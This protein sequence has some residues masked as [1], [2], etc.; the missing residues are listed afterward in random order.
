MKLFKKFLLAA[1]T[2]GLVGSLG[3]ATQVK[4]ADGIKITIDSIGTGNKINWSWENEDGD[5][6]YIK[7][8]S[9]EVG[10][11]EVYTF[12]GTEDDEEG[13][14][15]PIELGTE[16]ENH[17][18]ELSE[19]GESLDGDVVIYATATDGDEDS[20][21]SHSEGVAIKE[22]WYLVSANP[23]P[24]KGGTVTAKAGST[25]ITADGILVKSGTKV[26]AEEEEKSGYTFVQWLVNNT[27]AGT[28]PELVIKK[29][30]TETEIVAEYK[31]AEP[32]TTP[33]PTPTTTPTPTPTPIGTKA[34]LTYKVKLSDGT[35]TPERNVSTTPDT[36]TMKKGETITITTNSGARSWTKTQGDYFD[37]NGNDFYAKLAGTIQVKAGEGKGFTDSEYLTINITD[38]FKVSD[39]KIKGDDYVTGDKDKDYCIDLTPTDIVE[40]TGYKT[41][42]IKW[43]V[44]SDSKATL[45]GL[46]TTSKTGTSVNDIKGVRVKYTG[47]SIDAGKTATIEVK[48]T[49]TNGLKS[50]GTDADLVRTQKITVYPKLKLTFDSDK[51]TLAYKAPAK[52]N[53]GTTS[54]VDSDKSDSTKTA[55]EVKGVKIDVLVG[56]SV[57]DDIIDLSKT[58]SLGTDKTIEASTV[59]SVVTKL[60]SK[61][62]LSGDSC[63]VKFKV[64]PCDTDGKY[65][66]EIKSETSVTAYKVVVKVVGTASD[67]TGT[68]NKNTNAGGGVASLSPLP[69]ALIGTD[70]ATTDS[71]VGKEYVYY[72]LE[73]Q[74][75]DISSIGKMKSCT[76]GTTDVAGTQKIKVTTDINKNTYTAVLG[77]KTNGNTAAPDGQQKW[78]QGNAFAYIMMILVICGVCA[79]LYALNRKNK[80]NI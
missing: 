55:F 18:A 17:L 34:T 41:Y 1:A 9:V 20:A 43:E 3:F 36:V 8:G 28:D 70:V 75:I 32:T 29:I 5:F 47:D 27:P 66:K 10:G 7:E 76:N 40:G 74:E 13:V 33:T 56:D 53:T 11:V 49:I 31:E 52:V 69:I 25:N 79:G 77:V 22:P 64:S 51:R 50:S 46:S 2:V 16:I 58:K 15:T 19:K 24:K 72:G 14:Q 65:N 57:V 45:T 12:E 62:K 54:G 39:F 44:T 4:A 42:G 38:D 73:G 6:D 68:D 71:A 59:E 21:E 63:T 80:N 67:S 48:A 78:G 37:I 35:Y 26:T 61:G 30:E 60:N 23:K